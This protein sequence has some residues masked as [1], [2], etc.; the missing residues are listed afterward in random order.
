MLVLGK[1]KQIVVLHDHYFG[2]EQ[3]KVVLHGELRFLN[4]PKK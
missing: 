2:F 3:K 4:S 1:Q